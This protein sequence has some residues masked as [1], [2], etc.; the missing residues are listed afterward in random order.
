M[1][2]PFLFAMMGILLKIKYLSCAK[3]VK[4][5]PLKEFTPGFWMIAIGPFLKSRLLKCR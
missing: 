1:F 5:N 4:T 3:F 2:L